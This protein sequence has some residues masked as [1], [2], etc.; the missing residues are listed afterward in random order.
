MKKLLF[1]FFALFVSQTRIVAQ[2]QVPAP[3]ATETIQQS[4][5]ANAA[6]LPAKTEE[7]VASA[8]PT[9]QSRGTMQLKI[10]AG[11]PIDVEVAYTVSSLDIRPGELLS[12]RVLIPI[13]IDG[14]TAIEKDAL[15]KFA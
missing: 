11:T 6:T 2:N 4:Q 14:V 7:P 3:A 13:I 5:S 9:S 15:V 1:L 10:P 12:F 8:G